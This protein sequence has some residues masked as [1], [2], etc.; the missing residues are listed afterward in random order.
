MRN[1]RSVSVSTW[2]SR[3]GVGT[4][5]GSS[6]G[7]SSC[8]WI[9]ASVF[10]S[11]SSDRPQA[12]FPPPPRRGVRRPRQACPTPDLVEV[13]LH[14]ALHEGLAMLFPRLT[15]IFRLAKLQPGEHVVRIVAAEVMAEK[16]RRPLVGHHALVQHEDGIVIAQVP[17]AVGDRENHAPVGS[18]KTVQQATIS[19]S[20]CGSSPLVTSSQS[21]IGGL[22]VSSI[23]KASRR[24]CPPDSTWT[25]AVGKLRHI[26]FI[27]DAVDGFP[28]RLGMHAAH[29]QAHRIL[30]ALAHGQLLMRDAELRHEP[31]LGWRKIVQHEVAA[32]PMHLALL[33]AL[34]HAGDDLE[35]RAF[36]AARGP[37]IAPKCP[38]GYFALMSERSGFTSPPCSMK[39]VTSL[40]S[41]TPRAL[42]KTAPSAMRNRT[43]APGNRSGC[44]CGSPLLSDTS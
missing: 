15:P 9:S 13:V 5:S 12:V 22:L 33:L 17:Q 7:R 3:P 41:S 38:R 25:E 19:S 42:P 26:D 10:S 31:D 35:Q 36:A 43:V 6:S 44:L 16:L 23:A 1:L 21:R 32:I 2:L 8:G 28:Q 40:S 11:V 4:P 27:Q 20:D 30:H 39:R 37:M 24:F 14:H 18:G 29:A 34:G